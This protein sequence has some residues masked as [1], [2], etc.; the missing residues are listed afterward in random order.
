MCQEEK[1]IQ[2]V[3][4]QVR[5]IKDQRKHKGVMAQCEAIAAKVCA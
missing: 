3:E 5:A 1:E 2:K 4:I